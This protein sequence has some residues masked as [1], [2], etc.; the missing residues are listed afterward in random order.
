MDW[1]FYQ[2]DAVMDRTDITGSHF[3]VLT[4][5]GDHCLHHLFPTIDHG[6]LEYLYPVFNKVCDRFGVKLRM[7]KQVDLIIGQYRQLVK[8]KP[9]RKPPAPLQ[10]QKN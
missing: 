8:E 1:G 7:T 3:L 6:K 9:N 5:F 2:M 4:N 10:I